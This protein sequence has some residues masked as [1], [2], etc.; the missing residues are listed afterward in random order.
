MSSGFYPCQAYRVTEE[1]V[2]QLCPRE[3]ERLEKLLSEG[4]NTMVVLARCA[5]SGEFDLLNIPAG[6]TPAD[7]MKRCKSRLKRVVNKFK[8]QTDL[9]IYLEFQGETAGRDD[10]EYPWYWGVDF[11]SLFLKTAAHLVHAKHIESIQWVQFG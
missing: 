4:G 1:L 9:E 2:Q 3:L 8:R 6:V 11:D 7:Y 10:D 5:P